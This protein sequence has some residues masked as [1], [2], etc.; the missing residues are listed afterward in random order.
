M[1]TYYLERTRYITTIL[2]M[3]FLTKSHQVSV[4]ENFNCY[5]AN[6]KQF[7][8]FSLPLL[9]T[10]YFDYPYLNGTL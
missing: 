10:C 1:Q 4:L 6:K 5:A 7:F 3:K 2:T 9:Y 8:H